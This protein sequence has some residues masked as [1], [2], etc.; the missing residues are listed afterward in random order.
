MDTENTISTSDIVELVK[1]HSP[2]HKVN[3][4]YGYIIFGLSILFIIIRT[5]SIW[6]YQREWRKSGRS[7]S[8]L[9]I[10]SFPLP[11][12]ISLIAL[13][14]AFLMIIKP[15][16]EKISVS[17]KRLGRL[18][19]ALIPLDIF[20]TAQPSWISID[21]YLNTI[22]L[23]KWISR[24]IIFL[25]FIHSIGFFIYY[26]N[27]N[28]F[29]KVF[30]I[31]NLIGVLVFFDS[32]IMA[33]FWKKIRD[34]N[35]R[36]FYINHNIFVFLLVVLIY[37]HARPG[38]TFFFIINI[39]LLSANI[40]KKYLNAKDITMTEIIENPGSDLRIVKFPKTLLPENYLPG[41]H[42]RIGF[43]KWSPYFILFASH[44]YTVATTFENRDLLSSL[45]IKKS[46]FKLEPFE[47][48]SI[49]SNFK[50]SLSENFFN[51]VNN[52]SIVCGGSGISFGLGLFEYFKRC[53]IADGRDIKLKF[54]WITKNEED[55]FILDE[56]NIQGCDVFISNR[57]TDA[58]TESDDDINNDNNIP[59]TELSN[60]SD[61][62]LNS[63]EQK[64]TNTVIL[65]KRPNL[66][67]I[68][69]KNSSKTIDYANK[70]V[71][72]CGPATL[73]ADCEEIAKS[74]KCRFFSEEYSF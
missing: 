10:T 15:H 34:L 49:Q 27:V 69:A 37:F 5:T 61:Y 12:T 31:L 63:Y 40:I 13:I 17:I 45:I 29:N 4:K 48:Y 51:T 70:W 9:K 50:S 43:S 20:L 26:I 42:I 41:C 54:I 1:R 24:F 25:I 35:Y 64:F 6:F 23:H 59:L 21:N 28:K 52:L 72:S 32:I 18:A 44:P 58:L 30:K 3:I 56:L 66:K 22:Q 11:L 47:T 68:L 62:S 19:Y 46:N 67:V 33:L 8:L 39:I 14:V 65:G 71:V 36:F 60:N 57:T 38:V 16:Y 73:N 7:T 2:L 74:Q 55:T 53:I